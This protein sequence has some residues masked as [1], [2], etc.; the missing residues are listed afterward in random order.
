[1][2]WCLISYAQGQLYLFFVLPFTVDTNADRD[3][4]KFHELEFREFG[5]M[6]L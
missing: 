6:D 5:A 4:M 3:V 1:M 2:K